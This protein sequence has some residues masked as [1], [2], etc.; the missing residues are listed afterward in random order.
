M[1]NILIFG[2]SGH[3]M[4]IIDIILKK[5]N[6]N[7]KGYIDSFKSKGTS[8][9]GYNVI[10]DLESLPKIIKEHSIHAMVIG[11][12]DN[13]ARQAIYNS[14]VATAPN[15]EF[16]PVVHPSAII[17][18]D[19]VVSKGTVIMAGA[20]INADAKIGDFCILNSNSSLGHNSTMEDF[21]SLA[22]GA[23]L[24]GNVKIGKCSAVC[25]G[26]NIIQN[27]SIGNYTII[28][29]GSLVI[30]PI[31]DYKQAIGVPIHT[32]TNRE[33]DSKYLG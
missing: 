10:G 18:E 29:A 19:V 30:K 8:I 15:L 24:G 11:V 5:G 20:I 1:K 9:Y 31:G 16:I 17:A 6:Y 33:S 4:M 7:I 2:A 32:I 14:V 12:G 22:S 3:S 13:S 21:S 28:G 23:T 27:V 26:A 25:L